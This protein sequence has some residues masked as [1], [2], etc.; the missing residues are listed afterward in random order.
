MKNLRI[1]VEKAAFGGSFIGFS[2]GKAVFTDNVLP[3]EEVLVKPLADRGDYILGKTVEVL[4]TSPNRK[5]SPCPVWPRCGGC[6]YLHTDYE[7]ELELKK[8]ILIDSLRRI[9]GI[10]DHEPRIICGPRFHYRSHV[11]LKSDREGFGF[12]SEGSNSLVHLPAEG[13]LLADERLNEAAAAAGPGVGEVRFAVDSAGRVHT[14]D[15]TGPLREEENGL[16]FE[17]KIWNFYQ[18]NRFLRKEMLA[19]AREYASLEKEETFLDIGCGV[20]FFS[21]ALAL[22]G[23]RGKGI[24]VEKSSI[25]LA[26]ENALF[27]KIDSVSFASL[28]SSRLHPQRDRADVIL[29][30]PP[31]AGLDKKTRKTILAME[32]KR[33]VYISCNPATF[34]R[35]LSHLE[36]GGYRIKELSL[37]DMFP[38]TRHIESAALLVL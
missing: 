36:Q 2:E 18:A 31:R 24:D 19:L 27:N 34:A 11:T 3:G 22:Q 6:S 33:I 38:A 26:E 30:D 14:S 16:T 10:R 35:D 29:A 28:S 13:C 15:E 20:G 25:D 5:K 12:F 4:K 1:T 32:A 37:L 21:L 9:G 17:R 8:N 23:N 7:T